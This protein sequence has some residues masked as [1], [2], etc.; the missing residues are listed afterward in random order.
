MMKAGEDDRLI[1]RETETERRIAA[2]VAPVLDELGFRLVRIKV[3]GRDGAT[4]QIMAER[5]DG[6]MTIEGCSQIGRAL[7]PVFDVEDPLPG[8]YNLEVS[9]P[10]MD[11]PLVRLDDFHAAL[12]AEVK[13][14]MT[15]LIDGRRRFRGVLESADETAVS[16]RIAVDG[17]PAEPVE[18]PVAMIAEA[19][20][21]I[22]DEVLREAMSD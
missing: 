12:G 7:S 10:G 4:V 1:R 18:L 14:E 19:K 21:V 6:T 22:T 9:S 5:P 8:G 13:I 2:F 16:L 20:L 3:S 17:A 11:R 15:E